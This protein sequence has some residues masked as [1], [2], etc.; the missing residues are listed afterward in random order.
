MEHIFDVRQAVAN[1]VTL[2]RPGGKVY[3]EVPDS[4][5]IAT[6]GGAPFVEFNHK[7]INMFTP[8]TL[9]RMFPA[10]ELVEAEEGVTDG[11]PV[12]HAAFELTDYA[13][14]FGEYIAQSAARRTVLPTHPVIVWGVGD[15][16]M[17]LL[18]EGKLA[19]AIYFV[20]RNPIFTGETIIGKPVKQAPDSA[21]DILIIS[22]NF[23][24]EILHDIERRGYANKVMVLEL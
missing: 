21:E 2:T 20:D 4:L 16:T 11:F 10:L 12:V 15:S 23:A 1:I 19:N 6:R 22:P 7:H 9:A 18:G 13:S 24:G 3:V 17:R 8:G 5:R 14:E